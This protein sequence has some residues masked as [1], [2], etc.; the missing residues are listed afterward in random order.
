MR[1]KSLNSRRNEFSN[2]GMEIRYEY[3]VRV[4]A[5]DVLAENMKADSVPIPLDFGFVRFRSPKLLN[6]TPY[7]ENGL[8]SS[9]IIIKKH[10]MEEVVEE[11]SEEAETPLQRDR[12]VSDLR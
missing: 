4:R 3:I 1:L 11:W 5:L 10:K 9:Y 6:M 7:L 8:I 2:K 12:S